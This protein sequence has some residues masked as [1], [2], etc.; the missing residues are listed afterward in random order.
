MQHAAPLL[1]LP[2]ELLYEIVSYLEPIRATRHT[3]SD[4]LADYRRAGENGR[5]VRTL[6]AL[7]QASLRLNAIA[8]PSLYKNFIA[9]QSRQAVAKVRRFLRTLI[10]RPDLAARVTYLEH[11]LGPSDYMLDGGV[12][13]DTHDADCWS[14]D[15]RLARL[16]GGL[17]RARFG[18][19]AWG[20]ACRRAPDETH[21]LVL[22]ACLP[23]LEVVG[24]ALVRLAVPREVAAARGMF[25]ESSW[26]VLYAPLAREGGCLEKLREVVLVRDGD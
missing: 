26:R 3:Y 18:R 7:S 9:R 4:A 10:Q 23:N 14:R 20:V 12:V 25:G 2:N 1:T 22:M 15:E 24:T 17:A 19:M 16:V 5:R 8:T 6:W 11:T 13:V 21:L